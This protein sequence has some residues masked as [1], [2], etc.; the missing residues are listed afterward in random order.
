M[1][2]CSSI[3]IFDGYVSMLV[4]QYLVLLWTLLLYSGI[5]CFYICSIISFEFTC[6]PVCLVLLLL[7]F[8][9]LLNVATTII[10]YGLRLDFADDPLWEMV[11]VCNSY[12]T[13]LFVIQSAIT[14]VII[15]S[16]IY[17]CVASSRYCYDNLCRTQNKVF[18]IPWCRYLASDPGLPMHVFQ[19]CTFAWN[20]EKHGNAWVRG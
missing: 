6:V 9:L 8:G 19:R 15:C 4:Y 20:V 12:L 17:S 10:L 5:L 14:S 1:N 16:S 3:I 2:H 18:W 11:T 7:G 13:M